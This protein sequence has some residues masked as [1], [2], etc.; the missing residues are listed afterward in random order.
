MRLAAIAGVAGVLTVASASGCSLILDF[1]DSA[2]PGDATADSAFSQAECDYKEPNNAAAEAA[3]L[4][5]TDVGPAA[6]CAA[7][8]DDH[9]FY[10]F[11]VPASTASVSI[12]ITFVNSPTGDLDLRLYDKTGATV[13]AQ[14]RGFGDSETIACPSV[15]CSALAPDDYIFEVFPALQGAQNRYDIAL[16]IT[17]M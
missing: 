5:T 13:L 7:G 16:T 12:A 8:V 15:A 14:S 17:P 6:I 2:V 11:T 4:A 9:D 10:K 1:S 3:L